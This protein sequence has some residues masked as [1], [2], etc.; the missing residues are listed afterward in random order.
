MRFS[1]ENFT[2]RRPDLNLRVARIFGPPDQDA[3]TD[4]ALLQKGYATVTNIT[5]VSESRVPVF[6]SCR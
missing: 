5:S 2:L 4:A 6:A 1:D 3:G